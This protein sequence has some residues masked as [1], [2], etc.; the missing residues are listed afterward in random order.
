M[1]LYSEHDMTPT[2]ARRMKPVKAWALVDP[3][4]NHLDVFE[5]WGFHRTKADAMEMKKRCVFPKWRIVR[6]EIRE[7]QSPKKKR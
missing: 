5:D 2:P 7:I 6:V 3:Y 4:G 1:L